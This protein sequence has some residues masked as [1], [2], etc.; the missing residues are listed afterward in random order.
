[1][2][3]I[4]RLPLILLALLAPALA[5]PP[6][7]LVGDSTM[8]DKPKDPPNPE[9]GWGRALPALLSADAVR[10][11]NHA[12][13]GRSTT[14]FIAEG[15]WTKVLAALQT[16]DFVIMQF[17]HNDRKADK[18]G[19]YAAVRGAYQENFPALRARGVSGRGDAGLGHA[20]RSPEVE[21]GGRVVGYPR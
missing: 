9:T 19:V 7:H 11:V 3:K 12:M 15:R 6:L 21:W 16:G 4:F 13:N 18:P 17:G 8:A 5:S 1:M 20:G 14:S 2:P 10:V